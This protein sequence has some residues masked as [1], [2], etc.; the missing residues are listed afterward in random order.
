MLGYPPNRTHAAR[1]PGQ[2]WAPAYRA[3]A[4]RLRWALKAGPVL[5]ML[6]KSEAASDR[7]DGPSSYSARACMISLGWVV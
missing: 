1:R 7:I 3:A 5:C 2:G 6:G 4:Y